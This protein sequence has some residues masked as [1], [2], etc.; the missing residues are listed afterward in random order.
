[1]NRIRLCFA[2]AAAVGLA[3]AIG[4]IAV[5]RD[6]SAS[7][8]GGTISLGPPVGSSVP[9]NTTAATDAYSG[10]N[11][12]IVTST[13]PGV[14]VIGVTGTFAGGT[15]D[16]GTP[17]DVSCW[18]YPPTIY[19]CSRAT[20]PGVSMAGLLATFTFSA[21]GDG[22]VKAQLVH[23]PNNSL[24]DTYTINAADHMA[25]SNTVSTTTVDIVFGVGTA[26]DCLNVPTLTPT[27]TPTL[28]PTP[29]ITPTPNTTPGS[30][31]TDTPVPPPGATATPAGNPDDEIHVLSISTSLCLAFG[32]PLPASCFDMWR[33]AS[34]HMLADILTNNAPEARGCPELYPGG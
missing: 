27:W 29:T 26:T 23:E 15:I 20:G 32:G 25:Q 31:A 8:T 7:G 24:L 22:C 16:T 13:S 17:S 12:Q 28:S 19:G 2:A 34:Q 3:V 10:F 21:V 18:S 4:Y 9:V 33:P 14:W 1:M 5:P 6:T 11:V 30:I